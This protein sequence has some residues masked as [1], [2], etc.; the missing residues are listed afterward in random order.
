MFE[1]ISNLQHYMEAA[2]EALYSG[3][4]HQSAEIICRFAFI[5]LNKI[6]LVIRDKELFTK[7][8]NVAIVYNSNR[9][10]PFTRL[11]GPDHLPGLKC[12]L[13]NIID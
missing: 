12:V 5:K 10:I 13:P 9:K 6:N 3:T 2:N 8:L 11:L 4:G 7:S 1:Y